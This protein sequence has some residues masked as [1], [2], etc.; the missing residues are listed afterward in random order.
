MKNYI[1]YT[2]GVLLS[3]FGVSKQAYS[4]IALIPEYEILQNGFHE[5][6]SVLSGSIF[7]LA[8]TNFCP[9]ADVLNINFDTAQLDF[10]GGV[11]PTWYSL[12]GNVIQMNNGP[13]SCEHCD[14]VSINFQF[15]F[16]PG[17]TCNGAKA[18]FKILGSRQCDTN[19]YFPVEELQVTSLSHDYWKFY[20]VERDPDLF[21]MPDYVREWRMTYMQDFTGATPVNG[22][23]P[24]KGI[25]SHNLE[26]DSV[27]VNLSSMDCPDSTLRIIGFT[28]T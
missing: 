26:I 13:N 5:V 27:L 1:V 22:I 17:I 25:G 4:Q 24:A 23:Y 12:M 14:P 7:D 6:D 21:Y 9:G 20:S 10:L 18:G 2:I 3:L 16:K 19:T 28:P 11:D 8:I 15:R